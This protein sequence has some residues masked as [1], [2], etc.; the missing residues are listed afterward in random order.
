MQA[1]ASQFAIACDGELGFMRKLEEYKMTF[2]R[3]EFD[4]VISKLRA[5]LDTLLS[6]ERTPIGG[7]VAATEGLD[8]IKEVPGNNL[9]LHPADLKGMI[10]FKTREDAE[11]VAEHWNRYIVER[12]P[13]YARMVVKVMTKKEHLSAL[14]PH[15]RRM[16]EDFERI[17][18]GL[19]LIAE[20]EEGT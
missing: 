6:V 16:I 7:F 15:H 10:S 3:K 14:I 20:L 13:D 17:K 4:V 5:E 9:M 19:P 12:G 2:D 8:T 1:T 18:E 11:Q